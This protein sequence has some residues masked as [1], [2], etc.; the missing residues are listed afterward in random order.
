MS[1]VQDPSTIDLVTEPVVHH[2]PTLFE[3][4]TFTGF[5][6]LIR[7]FPDTWLALTHIFGNYIWLLLLL[8]ILG[9]T[10]IAD[11]V[12]RLVLVRFARYLQRHKKEF[13]RTFFVA[14]KAP[15]SF[16]IWL[17][18]TVFA[19]NTL[20]LT[21]K[22]FTDLVPY[23]NGFK[24]SLALIA[25]AWFSIRWVQKIE[26]YLKKLERSSSKWDPVSLEAL[27]KIFKLTVF[28]I[29]GIVVLSA[30]GVNLTGLIAFG[31]IGGVAVGFAAKDLVSNV[32]GGLMLYMD[33]PFV[34]G[35]WIRSPDKEIE[36]TVESIG[37]R[38]TIVRTF[39]KRPLYIPN[40]MFATISIENPSRMTN[41]R[42]KET[43][44]VRYCDIDQVAKITS[45]VKAMLLSHPDIDSNQTLI[46]SFN[47]FGASSLDM[48][49]YTFTKTT[50]WVEFHEVKERV[51]LK[52]AEIIESHGAEI[53]F[54]TRTLYIEDS[55][56]LEEVTTKSTSAEALK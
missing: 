7:M 51:L 11:F 39:D 53:A 50:V 56:K 28:I 16:Y 48:L 31:G 54:P 29:T 30:F 8:V 36:G 23:I 34:T 32:L 4:L 17:S 20:L 15:I 18:G 14:L 43:I 38:M 35:D 19:L 40:G 25:L 33:K 2:S 27:A 44:G 10:F 26:G 52:I 12:I 49:V 21:F 47:G 37:W 41:R 9:F 5:S 24:S 6:E 55:V 3:D 22:V 46:V 1:K 13:S 42:I 45:E